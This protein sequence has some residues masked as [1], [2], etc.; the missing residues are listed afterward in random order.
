MTFVRTKYKIIGLYK[1][2]N[3]T[4]NLWYGEDIPRSSNMLDLC[5]CYACNKKTYQTLEEALN[6][7]PNYESIYGCIW[8]E[9]GLIYATEL[10]ANGS[11]QLF[12]QY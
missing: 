2:D 11:L 12:G 8:T 6:K 7:N 4:I 5:D 9:D 3:D 1:V 10:K